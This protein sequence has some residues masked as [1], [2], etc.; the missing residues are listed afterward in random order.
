LRIWLSAPIGGGRRAGIGLAPGGAPSR[1]GIGDRI[2]AIAIV[3]AIAAGAGWIFR[4]PKPP[5]SGWTPISA[6]DPRYDPYPLTADALTKIRAAMNCE[7]SQRIAIMGDGLR[8]CVDS[9]TPLTGNDVRYM[10]GRPPVIG[11]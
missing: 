8:H 10:A 3:I 5:D 7:A 9:A 4:D 2:G 1:A 6:A 11:R